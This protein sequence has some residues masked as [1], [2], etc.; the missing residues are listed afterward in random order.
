MSE[1]KRVRYFVTNH[2]NQPLEL[3]LPGGQIVLGPRAEAEVRQSDLAA[4]QLGVLRRKR[5][6]TTREVEEGVEEP[7]VANSPED[8]GTPKPARSKGRN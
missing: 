2:Q 7:A 3:Y 6:L 1:G 8:A 5:L 4:A